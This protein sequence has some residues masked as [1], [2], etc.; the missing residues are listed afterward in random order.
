MFGRPA[1]ERTPDITAAEVG[2]LWQR[3]SEEHEELRDLL[4]AEDLP[5]WLESAEQLVR[6]YFTLED[7]RRFDPEAC[8]FA[9]E[10]EVQGSVPLRGFVD[11]LDLAST[12]EL[13]VVDYKTGRAPGEDFEASAL[14]QLKFYALMLYRL[15]GVVPTQ[16]KLIYLADGMSLQY[17]PTESE[18]ISFE[19]GVAALWRA[20]SEAIETGN[21]PPRPSS[22]CRFCAHQSLC[23]EFGGITPP[24][25]GP[26]T[27]AEAATNDAGP[28]SVALPVGP[29]VP[30]IG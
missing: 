16:L 27:T 21:F 28:G 25:P 19:N 5:G 23:P 14:Y 6:T 24:Y 9:V 22:W 4:P 18:L 17:A 29:T 30:V 8:E 15:R 12:G 20:I 1:Q 26:P 13:R 10:I 2:P 3:M 7:P 11:R